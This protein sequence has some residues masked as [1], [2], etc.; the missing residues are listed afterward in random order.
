MSHMKAICSVTLTCLAL[1]LGGCQSLSWFNKS[2][3]AIATAENSAEEYYRIASE[4]IKKGNYNHAS[5][6]LNNLR[7]FYPAGR[8]AEQALLD[9]IYASYQQ[10]EYEQA[11]DYANQFITLYPT[12]P[13]VDYAQYVKGVA[14]MQGE[15][16][17]LNVF[18]LDKSQRDTAYYRAAFYD[19][20]ILVSRYPN[21]IYAP[22]AAQRMTYIYNELAAHEMYV[23]DW[24]VKREAY[25]AAANRAKWV[26]QYYPQSSSVPHAIATM[27]YAYEQL[28]MTDT[29]KDYK[30]LLQINYPNLLGHQ[31]QVLLPSATKQSWLNKI[32]FGK[33]GKANAPQQS[34]T[35]GSHTQ[36]TKE[37]IISQASQLQLPSSANMTTTQSTKTN[38]FTNSATNHGIRFGLADERRINDDVIPANTDQ[39]NAITT[40]MPSLA[41]VAIEPIVM[42]T[43][44]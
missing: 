44:N 2:T 40:P 10:G 21:S 1:S 22:D 37:Q 30:T 43:T 15:S 7:T 13:R 28:G 42:P 19:F 3:D 4:A 18:N 31:G 29:A 32:S 33:L 6:N 26:F 16:G 34:Q 23:A 9:L 39:D 25:L 5:E 12:H 20:L 27:A 41:D 11:T 17:L 38:D 35:T 8:L 14:T 36:A 24:Y